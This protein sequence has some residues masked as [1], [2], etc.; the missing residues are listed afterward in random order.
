MSLTNISSSQWNPESGRYRIYE[1]ESLVGRGDVLWAQASSAL[2]RWKVKTRSG[3]T[4]HPES[5]VS[6]G[7]RPNLSVTIGRVTIQE[8]IEVCDVLVST[9]RIGYAYKTLAGHPI[10]GEESFIL[11]K[12][13]A[14]VVL[15]IR[16]LSAPSGE[17]R[18]RRRFA[19]LSMVQKAVRLRY[20]QALKPEQELSR[21]GRV[22]RSS[23][24]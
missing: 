21:L 2:M 7:S 18:W 6:L 11:Q 10:D 5:V 9:D 19:L 20:R 15:I 4:I 14:Q 22:L 16:S 12:R 1:Q 23:E 24:G 3:F 13:G 17:A 8:P